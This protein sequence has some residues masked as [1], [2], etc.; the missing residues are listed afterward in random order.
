M[1][2]WPSAGGFIR[3]AGSPL[4]HVPE[5]GV[6]PRSEVLP[7]PCRVAGS[8]AWRCAW[9]RLCKNA[10]ADPGFSVIARRCQSW[11]AAWGGW[12]PWSTQ[13]KYDR[14]VR[15]PATPTRNGAR[16]GFQRDRTGTAIPRD[17]RRNPPGP[18]PGRGDERVG[19]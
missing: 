12:L 17:I 4:G 1:L 15:C 19:G 9:V 5:V 3:P 2:M 13:A 18:D 6:R 16:N 10:G 14:L 7:P 11:T 8:P